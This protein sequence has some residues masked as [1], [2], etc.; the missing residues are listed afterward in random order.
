[1]NQYSWDFTRKTDLTLLV[2]DSEFHVHRFILSSC[3][4]V[5]NVMLE[6][7]NFVEKTC[8]IIKLPNKKKEHIQLMLNFIYPF[9]HHIT[10]QTDIN[11]LLNLSRE[12]Q[13]NKIR[14][15]CEKYLLQKIPT[16]EQ[17]IIAQEYGFTLL[18]EKCLLQL[19][20]K[21]LAL[22]Q[23]HPRYNE[24]SESNK[25]KLA[26]QHVKILQTYCK[27]TAQIAQASDMRYI[28]I[29]THV[30]CG[31]K[32]KHNNNPHFICHYCRASALR[33]FIKDQSRKLGL[34]KKLDE[35]KKS[36]L[37]I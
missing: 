35:F 24:L 21:A 36:E 27:K 12:Y 11:C 15:L 31:H 25:L 28:P 34:E 6:S 23:D 13:I 8:Q 5:F 17:L 3:S 9:G 14:D 18:K 32:P 29:A 7:D 26:E 22:L 1:M 30:Q 37:S 4:P 19:S 10:E 33:G 2:Q 20:E 16:V